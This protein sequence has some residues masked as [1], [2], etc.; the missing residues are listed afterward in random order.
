[1]KILSSKSRD[2]L[3]IFLC[4]LF[5]IPLIYYKPS[6]PPDLSLKQYISQQ[7]S[8]KN[9]IA[10]VHLF[11]AQSAIGQRQISVLNR[12]KQRHTHLQVLAL[13]TEANSCS[14]LSQNEARYPCQ[15]SHL[16]TE[17]NIT[18][19]SNIILVEDS[20]FVF[21]AGHQDYQQLIRQL[22]LEY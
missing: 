15:T 10:V 2:I 6:P 3:G 19:T 22:E 18:Q 8:P 4:L 9:Q 11:E 5:A 14:W 13:S 16:L 17:Q 20:Q 21:L 1:M 7:I 12:L